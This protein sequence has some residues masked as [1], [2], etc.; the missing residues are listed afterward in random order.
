MK[1]SV[2][3]IPGVEALVDASAPSSF[4]NWIEDATEDTVFDGL[5]YFRT[6]LLS[7]NRVCAPTV[8]ARRSALLEQGGFDP[9]LGFACDYAMWLRLCLTYRVGF[10]ARPPGPLSL[11]R[12]QRLARLPIRARGGGNNHRRPAWPAAVPGPRAARRRPGP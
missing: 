1:P 4:A 12:R 6:L 3:S 2:L 11:A 7:G 8:L 5:E 10:L 9:D